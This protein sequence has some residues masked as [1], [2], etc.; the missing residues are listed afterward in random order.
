MLD[1]HRDP[2][3]YRY[4][5]YGTALVR[6]VHSDATG[7]W[8]DEV[9]PRSVSDPILRDRFRFIAETGRPTWR[10]GQTSWSRDP[11]HRMVENCMVPLAADG[12]TVDIIMGLVLLFDSAGREIPG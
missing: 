7:R 9:E 6:S 8:M 11:L 5:L 4:R 3:R 2:L 1:V 10:R 12:T